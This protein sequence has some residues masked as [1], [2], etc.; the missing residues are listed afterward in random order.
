MCG[1]LGL[2]QPNTTPQ[3][4]EAAVDR[5][6]SLQHHRG[7]DESGVFTSPDLGLTLAMKR[8]S[9]VDEIGGRQPMISRDG[10]Y[11]LVYNGEVVNAKQLRSE[12]EGLGDVFSTDGSDTEVVLKVLT[13]FGTAG[14]RKLNGMFG[15]AVFDAQERHLLLARDSLGI[16]PLY[17][18]AESGQFAF[19]SEMKSLLTL[20]W[21]DTHLNPDALND[22]L[23]L[24]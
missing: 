15:I 5:M 19:A 10:R 1:I 16:K 24:M 20:P 21:V 14:L 7:P 9:I 22:Y 18:T 12:L 6:N 23:S 11:T 4:I 2:H 8:L 13:R 3:E 17:F